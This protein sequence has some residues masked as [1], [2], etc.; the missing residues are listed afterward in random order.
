MKKKYTEEEIE[1]ML[2]NSTDEIITGNENIVDEYGNVH[3][4]N[5]KRNGR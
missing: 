3:N 1:N 4:A 2:K 5:R